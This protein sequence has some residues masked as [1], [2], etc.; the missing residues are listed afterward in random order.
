MDVEKTTKSTITVSWF[1]LG[2]I[3]FF[4]GDEGG[5][6]EAKLTLM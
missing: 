6:R 4:I 5:E 1:L 2:Y 3:L